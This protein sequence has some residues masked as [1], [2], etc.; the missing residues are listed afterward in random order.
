MGEAVGHD[1]AMGFL[2]QRIVTNLGGSVHGGFNVAAFQCLARIVR[3]LCPQARKTIGLQ[4]KAYAQGVVF[5][6]TDAPAHD[7]HLVRDAQQVLHMVAY[8][9]CHDI[10]LGELARRAQLVAQ[11]LVKAQVDIDLLVTGAIKRTHGGL[12]RAAG[13]GGCTP[14][15]HQLGLLVLG[16]TLL[17]HVFPDIFRIGQNGRHKLGHAVIRR[18][19]LC[20]GL[21]AHWCHVATT[22]HAQNGQRVDTQRPACHQRDHDGAQPDA[23]PAAPCAKTATTAIV[24]AVFYIVRLAVAFPLHASVLSRGSFKALHWQSRPGVSAHRVPA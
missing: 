7:V 23:P 5:F 17:E 11:R 19:P 12:S 2:L 24:T 1:A 15:Q 10:G 6:F 14:K 13:R 18:W 3:F 20:G 8:L 21:L 22:Q 16:T 9:V 4:L